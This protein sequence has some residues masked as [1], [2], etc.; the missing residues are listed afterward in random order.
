MKYALVGINHNNASLGAL[1]R[2]FMDCESGVALGKELKE[3]Y[4]EAVILQTCNRFEC[5]LVAKEVCFKNLIDCISKHFGVSPEECSTKFYQYQ[6]IAVIRH[7]LV[8]VSSLDSVVLGES[9][10]LSQIRNAY[11]FCRGNQLTGKYLN[12]LFELAIR[13]GKRVRTETAISRGAVSVSQAA[14]EF[15]SRIFS[16]LSRRKAVVIGAGEMGELALKHLVSRGVSDISILN[17]NHQRALELASHYSGASGLPLSSLQSELEDADLVIVGVAGGVVLD[18]SLTKSLM[19]KRK[20]RKL[21]VADISLPRAV[22]AKVRD[23]ANIYLCDIYDLKQLTEEN[24]KKRG[25][26]VELIHAI[27]SEE[28]TE[29]EKWRSHQV[30]VPVFRELQ[31]W[32][33]SQYCESVRPLLNRCDDPLLKKQLEKEIRKNSGKTLHLMFKLLKESSSDS[34]YQKR[35]LAVV[36]EAIQ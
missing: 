23:L 4:E 19:Q 13:V 15:S 27:I 21:F 24:L 8:V 1:E 2:F 18:Y 17:R 34:E 30:L 11:T 26:E 5:Y 16:D 33:E 10:I 35:I 7:L 28:Q 14:V 22:D 12:R 20:F 32:R 36:Q 9:Q 6:D 29:F 3:L 31:K 25:G